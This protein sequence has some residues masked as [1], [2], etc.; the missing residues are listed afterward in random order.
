DRP[1][2]LLTERPDLTPWVTDAD[3]R[4]KGAIV[5]WQVTDNTGAPPAAIKA[6]FP[7]LVIEVP[8][9]FERLVQ[10]RLPLYRVG[11]AMIRPQQ[12]AQLKGGTALRKPRSLDEAARSAAPSGEVHPGFR[13]APS[14]LRLSR[15]LSDSPRPRA[16]CRERSNRQTPHRRRSA[17]GAPRSRAA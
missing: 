15:R 16:P 10:G 17:A 11:W 2:L 1:S 5:L 9:S 12:A 8:R 6:R 13:F 3:I 4:E 14:E 7:D